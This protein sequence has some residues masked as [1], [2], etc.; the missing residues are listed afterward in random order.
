M[1]RATG[2]TCLTLAAAA[3]VASGCFKL[4]RTSPPVEQYV[5]GGASTAAIAAPTAA[6][7]DT[8]GLSLGLRRLDLA[9]YL[10]TLA[11]VV[12]RADNEIVTTGF[13]RWAENPNAGLNRAVS[14]YLAVAPGIRAVDVAPWPIRSEHDYLVQLHVTRLEG[15]AP[16]EGRAL[17]GA[18][19]LAARWEIIRP[20]D[21][22]MVARGTSDHRA[23]DWRIN[24]YAGLV[25]RLD[26]GLVVL[27]RDVVACLARLGPVM[28]ADSVVADAERSAALECVAR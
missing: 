1:T 17:T 27:A 7:S 2:R 10:S 12:R 6:T 16:A 19:H 9:P 25:A 18:A 21:G 3:L 15:V 5:L 13:H 23:T 24:D 14:G 20:S 26:Q 8:V 11:I 4:A 22:A 28:P